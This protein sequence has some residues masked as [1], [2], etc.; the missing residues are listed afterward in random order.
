[1]L[2]PASH[3]DFVYYWLAVG[4]LCGALS[5]CDMVYNYLFRE[6]AFRRHKTR[7]V[8]G[9]F[10]PCL[11]AG[12]VTTFCLLRLGPQPILLLPG[13]WAGLFSLGIFSCRPYLPRA[14][15]WV[16]LYY[17]AASGFLLWTSTG[18]SYPSTWGMGTTF[19][20]GQILTALVHYW[21][22][23]RKEHA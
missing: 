11:V 19:G 8:F 2:V 14:I 3:V 16:A 6:D 15:G 17:L 13:L 23:E 10:A 1:M 5:S 4:A 22:I 12:L 20:V 18:G 7:R 21:D 9:Q